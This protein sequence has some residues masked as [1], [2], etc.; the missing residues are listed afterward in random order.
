MP[1]E[2]NLLFHDEKKV[3]GTSFLVVA[4]QPI[5]EKGDLLKRLISGIFILSSFAVKGD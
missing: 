3:G 5:T 4:L 1:Q 2:M